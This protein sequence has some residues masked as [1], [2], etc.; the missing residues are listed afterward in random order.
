MSEGSVMFFL[1]VV[2]VGLYIW[3]RSREVSIEASSEAGTSVAGPS[4]PA[5]IDVG[6][7]AKER[8][9]TPLYWME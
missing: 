1:A 6:V 5:V 4:I 2:V 9:R 3:A 8:R 7:Q